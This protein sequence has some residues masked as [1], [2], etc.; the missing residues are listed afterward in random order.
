MAVLP[1][2]LTIGV[3]VMVRVNGTDVAI[4]DFFFDAA[5]GRFPW[6]SSLALE[7]IGH[8]LPRSLLTVLWVGLVAC[9]VTAHVYAP[10][11]RRRSVLALTSAAMLAGPLVVVALK[12]ATTFPCPWSLVRYGGFAVESAHWFT[13]SGHAGHCVPAGHAAGGFS[14]LA[15]AFGLGASGFKR[16]A[17]LVLA[18][19]LLVGIACSAIR[20]LQ[21]AHFL[22]HT[23]WSA[24]IDWLVAG[25]IFLPPARPGSS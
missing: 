6:R 12:S 7:M 10:W 15:L 13:T 3:A 17:R 2:L 23:L 25:L 9:T 4:A 24:A 16:G 19:A 21:G 11:R 20:I 5:A 8:Q 1:P 22:S 14:L 18:A